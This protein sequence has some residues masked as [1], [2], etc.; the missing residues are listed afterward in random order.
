MRF[1]GNI[2]FIAAASSI[3][4][5]GD[6]STSTTEVVPI[7]GSDDTDVA[8][9]VQKIKSSSIV[10]DPT[11]GG[12]SSSVGAAGQSS[13]SKLKLNAG[14]GSDPN[15]GT[16][17][18][19]ASQGS[20]PKHEP[21]AIITVKTLTDAEK[22]DNSKKAKAFRAARKQRVPTSKLSI[23]ARLNEIF[24]ISDSMAITE[25][26]F[27]ESS[28]N[29][30]SLKEQV[31]QLEKELGSMKGLD[32]TGLSKEQR[33]KREE[34]VSALTEADIKL[35]GANMANQKIK[36]HKA[37]MNEL[38]D[39][40]HGFNIDNE[41]DFRALHKSYVEQSSKLERMEEEGDT[42]SMQFGKLSKRVEALEIILRPFLNH[43]EEYSDTESE[44]D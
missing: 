37:L 15:T 20:L 41:A 8:K 12:K 3:A 7:P 1:L 32:S 35:H 11:L 39:A 21:V 4:G 27:R 25:A 33:A 6:K 13:G 44:L 38:S 9:K 29:E 42:T 19:G 23:E 43:D 36:H 10:T 2:F 18:N 26:S 34:V 16:G 22:A 17:S 30:A 40:I 14:T 5:C 28:E 31:K 24:K